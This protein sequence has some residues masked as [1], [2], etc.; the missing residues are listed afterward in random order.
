MMMM[1]M[2]MTIFIKCSHY[3]GT[4]YKS[5]PREKRE[6]KRNKKVSDLQLRVKTN[7]RLLRDGDILALCQLSFPS[8]HQWITIWRFL[9]TI[10]Y[11]TDTLGFPWRECCSLQPSFQDQWRHWF[12][13]WRKNERKMQGCTLSEVFAMKEICGWCGKKSFGPEIFQN[14]FLFSE[15][16]FGKHIHQ[17]AVWVFNSICSISLCISK[18]IS[19]CISCSV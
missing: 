8:V 12:E 5:F 6:N 4:W 1:M 2:M 3:K 18:S 7:E 16:I 15:E 10:W 13:M 19:I 14:N 17:C 11:Y 9:Q